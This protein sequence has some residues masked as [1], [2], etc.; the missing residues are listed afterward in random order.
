MTISSKRRAEQRS[1][2][3]PFSDAWHTRFMPEYRRNR[4][5]GGTF[6]FTLKLLDR[7]S[8]LLVAHV[9]VLGEAVRRTRLRSLFLIDAWVVLPDHP[10]PSLPRKRRGS[11]RR[12]P[13]PGDADFPGR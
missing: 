3:P 12:T 9:D 1:A 10:H 11:G 8:D 7:R 2:I 13:M 6:F 4:V 5:P